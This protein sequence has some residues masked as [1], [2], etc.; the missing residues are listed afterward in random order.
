VEKRKALK[1]GKAEQGLCLTLTPPI[2]TAMSEY[3]T[4]S[5]ALIVENNVDMCIYSVNNACK[6][7]KDQGGTARG[8]Q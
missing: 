2:F 4:P 5:T 8:Q 3:G 7:C 1:V 6:M